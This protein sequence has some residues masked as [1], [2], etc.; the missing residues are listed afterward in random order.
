MNMYWEE[1]LLKRQNQITYTLQSCPNANVDRK[2]RSCAVQSKITCQI[3]VDCMWDCGYM[4]INSIKLDDW[5]RSF[6]ARR[7]ASKINDSRHLCCVG[8]LAAT[9]FRA[10]SSWR[11]RLAL[12]LNQFSTTLSG[13]NPFLHAKLDENICMT[14]LQ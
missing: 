8:T 2:I 3:L 9:S 6:R 4:F 5:Q 12:I 10:Q 11:S 1:N 14:R 7:S 13:I